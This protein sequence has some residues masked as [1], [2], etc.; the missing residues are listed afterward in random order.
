[1]AKPL[2]D[3]V[4]NVEVIRMGC[5]LFECA[6]GK[7][8]PKKERQWSVSCLDTIMREA[9][10]R[11]NTRKEMAQA[12]MSKARSYCRVSS[13]WAGMEPLSTRTSPTT[14]RSRVQF[15]A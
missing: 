10:R 2:V 13:S 12:R 9:A 8:P 11:E 1:M 5:G 15:G 6:L 3:V 7:A 4:D 14:P